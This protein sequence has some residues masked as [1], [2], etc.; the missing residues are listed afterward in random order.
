MITT[1]FHL[2]IAD[3]DGV[4]FGGAVWAW[5]NTQMLTRFTGWTILGQVEGVWKNDAGRVYREQLI[6]YRVA[7]DDPEVVR[8]FLRAARVQFA[9]EAMYLEIGSEAELIE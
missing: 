2:P 5:V 1:T 9:Q 4:P 6:R 3:N 7:V 8:E